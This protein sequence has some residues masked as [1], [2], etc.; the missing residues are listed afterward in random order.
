MMVCKNCGHNSHCG[1]PL[2]DVGLFGRENSDGLGA[3]ICHNCICEKCEK[4]YEKNGLK[5]QTSIVNGKMMKIVTLMK[6]LYENA[7]CESERSQTPTMV[8]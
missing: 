5:L 1:L 6:E 8:S 3:I 7:K 2:R 4:N